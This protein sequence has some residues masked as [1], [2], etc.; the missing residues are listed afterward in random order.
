MAKIWLDVTT[1]LAW[2]RPA[3]GVVRLETEYAEYVLSLNSTN[4]HFC[5]YQIDKGF[6][7]VSSLEVRSSLT[8]I[9][10]LENSGAIKSSLD[11]LP[12]FSDSIALDAKYLIK[13]RLNNLILNTIRKLPIKFQNPIIVIAVKLKKVFT[14]SVNFLKKY[15]Y[16]LININTNKEQELVLKSES[17]ANSINCQFAS[18]DIYI[19][20][21]ADWNHSDVSHV[22]HAK[23]KYG[24][25]VILFCYDIIPIKLPHLTLEWVAKKFPTYYYNI[26][27]TADEILCI[28]E[29]SK[30][31]LIKFLEKIGTPIPS[32][33]VFR[34]GCQ[35][36]KYSE[37]NNSLVINNLKN[38]KY[39]LYVSTIERR[40]NHEVLYRAYTRLIDAGEK[41]LPIMIFVGMEG[42]GVGELLTDIRLDPRTQKNILILNKVTDSELMTLYKYA[43]FTVYPSLYEG[44][45]LPVAESLAAGKFCLASNAAS[46]PEIAGDLI[47][48]LDPWN[49]PMWVERLKWYFNNPLAIACYEA[50]IK[51]KYK[52]TTWNE[53][54]TFIHSRI[55]AAIAKS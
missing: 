38:Q 36:P 5:R 46:I 29:C 20:M 23:K 47:E 34:L 25:K 16:K 19:S 13:L 3:V 53:A 54:S 35:L 21:G 32:L 45:G 40:K 44:W 42:W 7:E 2:R 31:D 11:E 1:T 10:G 14:N 39:I 51:I 41:N 12:L 52:S 15:I 49:L 37:L 50:E 33:K 22:Y 24:L 28:S 8:R 6:Q 17:N 18:D 4:L 43:F 27:W 26:A 55:L 9:S 30:K 48:Y